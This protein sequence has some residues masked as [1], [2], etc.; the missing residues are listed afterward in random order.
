ME[1]IR[2]VFQA[3]L[4][5]WGEKSRWDFR[6]TSA[7]PT[8]SGIIGLL[9]CCLGVERRSE[10]LAEL[11]NNL[12]VAVR[13]DKPGVIITD[14]HTVQAPKGQK[15]LNAEG[16]PRGETIVTPK[17]YIQ[18]A[19]FTVL[20]WGNNTT[21]RKCYESLLHPHWPAYLGR[22][23]CVPATPLKPELVEA[24][25]VYAALNL[26]APVDTPVKAEIEFCK[27]DICAENEHII[28]RPDTPINA[29]ENIYA[30][31]QVKSVVIRKTGGSSE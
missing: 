27:N 31:R 18:D 16:K 25:D 13:A 2:L 29:A 19:K 6:D 10:E 20:L 24:E 30:Y 9:G 12:R 3:P 21:M 1:F 14:F 4:Q 15:L 11:A 7:M 23:N 22:K 28:S 17:Q 8:K 5:S 26:D